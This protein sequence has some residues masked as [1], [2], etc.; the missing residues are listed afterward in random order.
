MAA[1]PR[2][3][4]PGIPVLNSA[5]RQA[6]GDFTSDGREL[7]EAAIWGGEHPQAPAPKD[8]EVS[9]G[10]ACVEHWFLSSGGE[11]ADFEVCTQR[12]LLEV[13]CGFSS[14]PILTTQNWFGKRELHD[15]L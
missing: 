13:C 9:G 3:P 12:V 6:G 10:A 8:A 11:R 5:V 4:L 7:G 15:S 1:L 14:L 2:L